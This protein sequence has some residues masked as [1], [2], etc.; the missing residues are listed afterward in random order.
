MAVITMSPAQNAR[1][2]MGERVFLIDNEYTRSYQT[3]DERV[4]AGY[5][6]RLVTWP[7]G[8]IIGGR[9]FL[10]AASAQY[11][12]Q[13]MPADEAHLVKE[14]RGGNEV[15]FVTLYGRHRAALFRF[16]WRMTGS[17]P[18]AED[19]TQECFL[20]LLRGSAFEAGRARLQT[21]LFGIARLQE[22]Q[23]GPIPIGGT[24]AQRRRG[25]ACSPGIRSGRCCGHCSPTV[26]RSRCTGK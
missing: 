23:I 24:S 20:A 12:L 2:G 16:A 10:F 15:A 6:T 18:V 22:G 4:D 17:L 3:W 13:N 14:A 1:L 11:I 25:M 7:E 5:Q 8:Q 19:V 21:Y 26:S 9:A